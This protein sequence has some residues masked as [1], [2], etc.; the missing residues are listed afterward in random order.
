M[1]VKHIERRK[2]EATKF[3]EQISVWGDDTEGEDDDEAEDM[4]Q[5]EEK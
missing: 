5:E 4:R 3:T 2:E 1:K